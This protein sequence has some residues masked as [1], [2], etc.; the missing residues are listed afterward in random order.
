M[1]QSARLSDPQPAARHRPPEGEP[2]AERVRVP[3]GD[4]G[5][6]RRRNWRGCRAIGGKLAGI[7]SDW[8]SQCDPDREQT[9]VE[10][11]GV[12]VLTRDDRDYPPLL[13]EIHDPPLCLYVPRRSG[14]PGADARGHLD[15]GEPADDHLRHR[16]GRPPGHGG[17]RGRLA[18]RPPGWRGASTRWRTGPRS[19][20]AARPW[21]CSAAASPTS[22]RRKTSTW[23]RR[24]VREGGALVTEFPMAMRPDKRNFPM[25][26]R[27]ISGLTRG[28]I[29][30][31]AGFGSG[32]LITAATATDQGRTVF[33]VP[34]RV[35]SPQSRGWPRPAPGRGPAGGGTFQ[36]VAEEFSGLPGLDLAERGTKRARSGPNAARRLDVEPT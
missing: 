28:T 11:A 24:I 29:V 5:S 22:T 31:E 10:Q 26:N 25:R 15:R 20:P 8:H 6:G 9:M 27:I 34:G 3:G 7:I 35:D 2:V 12:L 36:D 17:R 21:P 19:T 18:G 32:S 23:P 30:V 14:G 13:A 1:G 4:S 16:R 33:A